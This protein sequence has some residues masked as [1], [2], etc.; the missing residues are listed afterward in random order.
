MKA[1]VIGSAA[2]L[3]LLGWFVS[4]SSSNPSDV[5]AGR[6]FIAIAVAFVLL[7]MFAPVRLTAIIY[8]GS[9]ALVIIAYSL[10][11]SFWRMVG[12]GKSPTIDQQ[13][14]SLRPDDK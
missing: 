2:L 9:I 3:A 6:I 11:M 13:S 14:S 7:A 5:L 12:L 8:F 10:P 4:A 1:L